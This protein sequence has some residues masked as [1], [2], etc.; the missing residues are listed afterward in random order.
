MLEIAT[1]PLLK[2]SQHLVLTFTR[3][4][5]K[6]CSAE[7]EQLG[8]RHA[9]NSG[10]EQ[11]QLLATESPLLKFLHEAAG[12]FHSLLTEQSCFLLYLFELHV[13]MKWKCRCK[14][15]ELW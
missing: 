15:Q 9:A 14:L 12:D 6:A 7:L 1:I 10:A 4:N 2:V 8:K 13:Q 3:R 5:L 11:Q